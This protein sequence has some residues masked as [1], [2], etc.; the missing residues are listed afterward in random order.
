MFDELFLS[1][2]PRFETFSEVL[3]CNFADHFADNNW[4][5]I[6]VVESFSTHLRLD[7]GEEVEIAWCEVG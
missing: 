7:G 3:S 2:N 6:D 5:V 1:Y 4:K